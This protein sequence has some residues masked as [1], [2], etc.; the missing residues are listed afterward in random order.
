LLW[1]SP[2]SLLFDGWSLG[3]HGKSVGEAGELVGCARPAGWVCKASNWVFK[4]GRGV[5][6]GKSLGIQDRLG[7]LNQ[8]AGSV[9][10][11][12]GWV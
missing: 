6:A 5:E 11:S 3:D 10:E 12:R 7:D 2:N 4:V 8:Q 9:L 1:L